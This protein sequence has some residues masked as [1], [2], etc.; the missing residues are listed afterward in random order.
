MNSKIQT[1]IRAAITG[2]IRVIGTFGCIKC[3]VQ[4][5]MLLL[6]KKVAIFMNKFFKIEQ[7]NFHNI[8]L[9]PIITSLLS[10]FC[11]VKY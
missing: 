6:L 11:F 4:Y 8:L 10:F 3:F 1:I 5:C 9:S 2:S 7:K